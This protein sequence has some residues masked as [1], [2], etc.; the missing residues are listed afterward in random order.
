MT[1]VAQAIDDTTSFTSAADSF[2][3]GLPRNLV[4]ISDPHAS[5]GTSSG[6]RIIPL[7]GTYSWYQASSSGDWLCATPL[8]AASTTTEPVLRPQGQS[9]QQ[10]IAEL[11]GLSGLTWEQMARLLGVSRRS[12]H[13]WASGEL[14]RATHQERVQRLLAV[15]RQV[16]RGSATENRALLLN[17][18]ADGT[19][20]FD[21]LADGRFDEAV[22]LMKKGPGRSRPALTPLSA[23]ERLARTPSPPEQLV[24]AASDR[25]HRELRGARQ[26][27]AH[28]VHK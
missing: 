9:V 17:G 6:A 24:G 5:P 19:L 12:V 13:F 4:L 10:A 14:V 26:A 23:E 22:E 20:P 21:V 3:N 7:N 8:P 27:R 28:R 1:A 18:C 2:R 11:R 16:D 25:V 15:L